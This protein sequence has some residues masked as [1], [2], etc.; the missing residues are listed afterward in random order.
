MG[1]PQ[2][3]PSESRPLI[4]KQIKKTEKRQQ[5]LQE[6]INRKS[7]GFSAEAIAKFQKEY[8]DNVDYLR[9]LKNEHS[10]LTRT[11]GK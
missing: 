10:A 7:L 5:E 3:S 11:K 2:G 8:D 4:H 1:K 9:D 6:F